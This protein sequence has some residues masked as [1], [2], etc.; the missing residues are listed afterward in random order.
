MSSPIPYLRDG[1]HS[2]N[3]SMPVRGASDAIA[4]YQRAFGAREVMR[5][6]SPDGKIMHAELEIGGSRIMLHDEAPDWGSVSPLTVGGCPIVLSLYVPD[7]DSTFA[8]AVEAGATVVRPVVP[9][10]WGDRSGMIT[11]PFGYRWTISTQVEIVTPEEIDR[12]MAKFFK[13][14]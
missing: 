7:A 10:P 2:I 9:Q 14:E 5:M 11:D 8:Q 3:P 1:F 13:T 6:S 12:R 4:F